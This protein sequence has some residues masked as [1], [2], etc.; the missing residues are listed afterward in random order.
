ML[1]R[2]AEEDQAAD[3]DD[4]GDVDAAETVF[5]VVVVDVW[6]F[7]EVG[8]QEEVVEPVAPCFCG[9][10]ADHWGE[11]E[12]SE[13]CFA[14]EVG[15]WEDQEGDCGDDADGPHG[16]EHAEAECWRCCKYVLR[17]Q[18]GWRN[19]LLGRKTYGLMMRL[20]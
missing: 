18:I 1:E 20:S 4:P 8:L 17:M 11:E 19:S 9:E 3:G 14:E 13:V 15:G 12:E 2:L 10:G 16:H 7:P 6:V 5:G